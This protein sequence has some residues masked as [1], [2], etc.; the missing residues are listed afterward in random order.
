MSRRLGK[1]VPLVPVAQAVDEDQGE[2]LIGWFDLHRHDLLRYVR[3]I[4]PASE[5]PEDMVQD[6]FYRLIR[7]GNFADLDNPRAYL[8]TIARNVAIDK[9]RRLKAAPEI[10]AETDSG[11]ELDHNSVHTMEASEMI[12]AIER[13]MAELPERCREA[14]VLRR[15]RGMDTAETAAALGISRR[16]VQRHLKNAMAHFQDRLG[17]ISRKVDS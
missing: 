11:A 17:L 3:R 14:F 9:L 15:Y 4:L 13:A 12:I 16:M 1:V 7:Q 6:V 5:S 10:I 8:M 2:I